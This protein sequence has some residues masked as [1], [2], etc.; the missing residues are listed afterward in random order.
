[1]KSTM[2]GNF[3]ANTIFS[4]TFLTSPRATISITT[5]TTPTSTIA[6]CYSGTAK[7]WLMTIETTLWRHQGKIWTRLRIR[8]N[9]V[10]KMR[11]GNN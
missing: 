11:W 3:L 9:S 8:T 7:N 5:T 4:T 2:D 1:L 10:L 6:V